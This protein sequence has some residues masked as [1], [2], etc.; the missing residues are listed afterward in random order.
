[1]IYIFGADG[2]L[3]R[4]LVAR[5]LRRGI[6]YMPIRHTDCDIA[7]AT[8][9]WSVFRSSSADSTSDHVINAAGAIPQR[10][11]SPAEM[12]EANALGPHIVASAAAH[13]GLKVIHISTDCV[14][15]GR[16]ISANGYREAPSPRDVY[17]R[18][19]LAGE[20]QEAHVVNVRTSFVGPGH[21]LWQWIADH[22]GPEIEG[23]DHALWSGSTVEA[24]ADAVLDMDPGVLG[25]NRPERAKHRIEDS[26]NVEHLSTEEPISKYRSIR[27]IAKRIGQDLPVVHIPGPSLNRALRPTIVLPPLSEALAAMEEVRW[28]P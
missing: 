1:M 17:G 23:W 10:H 16:G 9:I 27:L 22:P 13:F 21:G 24:V 7:N 5:A 14:F 6:S 28:N 19:K 15:D 8:Q 11:P 12:I 26:A 20:V 2:M 4:Y 18:S 25:A 3:G